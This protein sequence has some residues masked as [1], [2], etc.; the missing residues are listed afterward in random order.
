VSRPDGAHPPDPPS[1]GAFHRR[2][3][4]QQIREVLD[5]DSGQPIADGFSDSSDQILWSARRGI[6]SQ[7]G[8]DLAVLCRSDQRGHHADIR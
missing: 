8:F 6:V 3:G 1:Y 2:L 7:E 5:L 4:M